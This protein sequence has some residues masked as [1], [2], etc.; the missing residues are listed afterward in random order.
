M[1]DNPSLE[2]LESRVNE[3]QDSLRT[4]IA[5]SS[6]V[7]RRIFAVNNEIGRVTMASRKNAVLQI[8]L[9]ELQTAVN[10]ITTGVSAVDEPKAMRGIEDTM[11]VFAGMKARSSPQKNL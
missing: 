11:V 2:E 5:D 10:V 1:S 6:A 4:G 3:L 9:V 8:Q 7:R